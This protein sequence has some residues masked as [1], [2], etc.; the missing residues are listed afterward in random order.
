MTAKELVP[1]PEQTVSIEEME[2]HVRKELWSRCHNNPD[3]SEATE[4]ETRA[5]IHYRNNLHTLAREAKRNFDEQ[6]DSVIAAVKNAIDAR[7]GIL[8]DSFRAEIT[9][10]V[11]R[12]GEHEIRDVPIYDLEPGDMVFGFPECLYTVGTEGVPE[13]DYVVSKD[14]TCL[15]ADALNGGITGSIYSVPC[16][17]YRNDSTFFE[18]KAL[19]NP[20]SGL[21]YNLTTAGSN[22][23]KYCAI[24][25]GGRGEL[26]LHDIPVPFCRSEWGE[27]SVD[28]PAILS[29]LQKNQSKASFESLVDDAVKRQAAQNGVNRE[30]VRPHDLT[31]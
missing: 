4:R 20:E 6:G 11:V 13:Q 22:P 23:G 2:E 28:F 25:P 14:G 3:F 7:L 5:F 19:F 30:T 17:I 26:R 18:A 8:L 1:A 16:R 31:H 29:K 24:P 10:S 21:L 27:H 15:N 12:E 9:V